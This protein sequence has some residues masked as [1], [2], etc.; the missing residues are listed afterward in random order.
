MNVNKKLIKI[1]NEAKVEELI[2]SVACC[3]Y[4]KTPFKDCDTVIPGQGVIIGE[5]NVF[6]YKNHFW[7][8]GCIFDSAK[9]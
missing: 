3:S 6:K 2:N 4:C 9:T 7:H 1:V 8:Y 5:V